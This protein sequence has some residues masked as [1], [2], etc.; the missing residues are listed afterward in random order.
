[1]HIPTPEDFHA[2]DRWGLV[3]DPMA[4][5]ADYS[6][7][8]AERREQN[9]RHRRARDAHAENT[10]EELLADPQAY[11][12]LL[13]R[14]IDRTKWA[15]LKRR[16]AWFHPPIGWGRFAAP[17]TARVLDLGCGDGDQTQRVAE[18]VAGRWLETDFDGFPMEIVGVDCNESRVENARRHATSPH[19]KITL[20]F[21]HGD[22][23]DGL[24]Y[25]DDF[26]DYTLATGLFEV[27][28]DDDASAV[29][30]ETGRLTAAGVYVRDLLDE[31]PGLHPRPD[32]PERLAARGFDAVERHR[33]FE[34]PFV[35]EGT[36][37]PLAVW[38]M[39]RHQVVFAETSDPTP[40]EARY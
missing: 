15:Y 24:D 40:P 21:E 31:Y 2:L 33:V 19:P 36:T 6:E 35:E 26:F 5:I 30:D 17:G 3:A 14:P 12:R 32:L 4:A 27:L 29:L 34:E 16:K 23:V 10:A 8:R 18:F 22:A 38:P 37:D 28:G 11:L 39:N 1:M 25:G 20:R 7:A 13:S 9:E